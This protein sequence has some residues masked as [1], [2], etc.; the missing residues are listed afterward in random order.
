MNSYLLRIY[1][2]YLSCESL[3]YIYIFFI[4]I[5]PVIIIENYDLFF[6]KK[7][8]FDNLYFYNIIIHGGIN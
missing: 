7:Y 4:I 3:I 6:N 2:F 8:M 1:T 5:I